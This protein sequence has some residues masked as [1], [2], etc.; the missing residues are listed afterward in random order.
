MYNNYIYL[1]KYESPVICNCL[2]QWGT[3]KVIKCVTSNYIFHVEHIFIAFE[4]QFLLRQITCTVLYLP[5]NIVILSTFFLILS[6]KS[7]N[8]G[9]VFWTIIISINPLNFNCGEF[10]FIDLSSWIFESLQS[11]KRQIISVS[12]IK[13]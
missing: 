3:F 6:L 13:V 5:V 7:M 8:E 11:A 2:K 10:L 9:T 4:F 1:F 12:E